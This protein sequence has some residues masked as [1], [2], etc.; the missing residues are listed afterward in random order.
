MHRERW[1]DPGSQT[2]DLK[3]QN[4]GKEPEINR[5]GSVVY[6]KA[7]GPALELHR[8]TLDS[9]LLMFLRKKDEVYVFTCG[10]NGGYNTLQ[11]GG[12]YVRGLCYDHLAAKVD[13]LTQ[14]F[15]KLN[16][17]T[18]T[19]SPTSPPCEICGIFGHFGVDC[20]LGSATNSIEQL[21]YAQYNQRTRPNQNF[22][23][24]PQGSYGQVA[25]PGYTN[26]QRVAQKPSF[27][28]AE[29]FDGL[30][31]GD[32]LEVDITDQLAM[33]SDLLAIASHK[34]QLARR[35]KS[36]REASDEVHPSRGEDHHSRGRAMNS[37]SGRMQFFTKIHLITWFKA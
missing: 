11:K 2:L 22:Y 8:S 24:N 10:F 18:V 35:R 21:N 29:T 3:A 36:V 20:Q 4:E 27:G 30:D 6:K 5:T 7:W 12:R 31:I 25:P 9:S 16:V 28:L 19:P 23:K 13:A 26:N 37:G 14:K 1:I 33:A 34:V 32:D 15:E 17:N